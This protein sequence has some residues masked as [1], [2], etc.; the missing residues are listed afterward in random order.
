MR[1][2]STAGNHTE[3]KVNYYVDSC[4]VF[5]S[6][7]SALVALEAE[8]L[9]GVPQ[10]PHVVVAPAL[11]VADADLVGPPAPPPER[12]PRRQDNLNGSDF[13]LRTMYVYVQNLCLACLPLR[14]GPPLQPC[15]SRT[16]PGT[17]LR[18]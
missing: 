5:F 10:V 15:L 11:V 4:S 18:K 9:P 17:P 8:V 6:F 1:S 14:G 16:R 2:K 7:S 13:L 3:K 12:D